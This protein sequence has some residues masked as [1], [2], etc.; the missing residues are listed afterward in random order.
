MV[1]TIGI[2]TTILAVIGVLLS[3]RKRIS[4]YGFWLVSNC[5]SLL[6]HL[7]AGIYS[8]AVRDFVFLIL[9]FDGIYRWRKDGWVK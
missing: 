6:I 8:L 7:H 9:A 5:L 2:L 1:E 3:N 4:C